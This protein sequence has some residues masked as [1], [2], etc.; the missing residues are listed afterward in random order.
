MKLE[1]DYNSIP[2]TMGFK[3]QFDPS[4]TKIIITL[5]S[6]N[7]QGPKNQARSKCS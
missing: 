2:K 5:Y 4:C 7:I 1:G 3:G 6:K